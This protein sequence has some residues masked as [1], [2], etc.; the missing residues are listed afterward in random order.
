VTATTATATLTEQ[1]AAYCVDSRDSTVDPAALDRAKM[2]L[3]DD[4]GCTLL[5]TTMP[6]GQLMLQHVESLA[7]A[8]DVTIVGTGKRAAA[9][10]AA[11]VNGL[12]NHAVELDGTHI[13]E[14][15]PSAIIT[16][17]C[18]AMAE[19]VSASGTDLARAMVLSYDV[20]TRLVRA[21]GGRLTAITDLHLH[22][23]LAHVIGATAGVGQLLGLDRLQMQ[24]AFALAAHQVNMPAA[25]FAE[26]D[27]FTKAL[28]CGQGAYAA[29]SGALMASIGITAHPD[30]IADEHGVLNA[31]AL[32]PLW[33]EVLE[34][35]G[36][37][38][39][40]VDVNFKSYAAGYPIHAPVAAALRLMKNE[41]IGFDDLDS[42]EVH[43][44]TNSA[45]LVDDRAMK[46]ISVQDMVA[47]AMFSGALDF[48]TVHPRDGRVIPEVEAFRNR[49]TVVRDAELDRENRDGRGAWILVTLKDGRTLREN[50][51]FPPWHSRAG[52]ISWEALAGKFAGLAGHV[53]DAAGAAKV[54]DTIAALE[55]VADVHELTELVK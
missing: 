39:A 52:D 35:L 24:Y 21:I 29:I 54:I 51:A 7:S 16:P 55:N 23:D 9:P 17:A 38:F 49:V 41:S 20:G 22:S 12:E 8:G 11:L 18:L 44:T 6:A 31:W 1:L 33:D 32:N 19:H 25:F 10:L 36:E 30:I 40:I 4:L 45:Q 42:V 26:P 48:D 15:H 47:L 5:G 43:M 28:N 50:Q 37:R 46:S 34:G 2:V 53:L 3:L 13:T 27:H 14:G